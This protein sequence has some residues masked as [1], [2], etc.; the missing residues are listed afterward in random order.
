M[1]DRKG[2]FGRNA[3]RTL[4]GAVLLASTALSGASAKPVESIYFV[5]PLPQF[6]AWRLIGDCMA[7]EAEKNGVKLTETG[8][9]DGTVNT[10]V[11]MQQVQQG[12]SNQA[13]AIVTFPAADGFVPLLEQAGN[14]GILVGTLYGSGF[15]ASASK[16]NV[17]ANFATVG[18]IMVDTLIERDG[19]QNVGLMVQGP[20]GAA[21]EYQEAF[22]AAAAAADNVNVVATVFT[23]DNASKSLDQANALLTAHP[24]INVIASHMGTA[25]Q[26]TVAAI[27]SRGLQGKVVMLANGAAGGGQEGLQ[28]GTVYRIMMQNLCSAG[29]QIVDGLVKIGKGEEVPAQL[30][31]GI[32]MFGA[33]G[34]QQYLDDGWQ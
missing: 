20:S 30:D 31:V 19:P 34:L 6:P 16:V 14:A 17:G 13:D 5:N 23:E 28:D 12:I 11:M 25:T 29:T 2:Q 3:V 4:L 22:E 21:K 1:K 7:T 18:K 27:T 10:T 33:D 9:T 8:P 15:T 32:Q 26:G 24:E